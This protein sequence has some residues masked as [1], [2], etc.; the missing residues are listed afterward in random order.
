MCVLTS[1]SIATINFKPPIVESYQQRETTLIL[2]CEIFKIID[3]STF[4]DQITLVIQFWLNYPDNTL[5]TQIINRLEKNGEIRNSPPFTISLITSKY[6]YHAWSEK[7]PKYILR[8]FDNFRLAKYPFDF[9]SYKQ[10][11]NNILQYWYYINGFTNE[12]NLVA[13]RIFGICV[14]AASSSKAL[15]MKN[16]RDNDSAAN[17]E[18][19]SELTEDDLDEKITES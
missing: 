19:N 12:L 18:P 6:Y 8:E 1:T 13:C 9:D 3:S 17:L 5:V 7:V 16:P 10:F 4:W 2:L 14:N 11:N 15:Q